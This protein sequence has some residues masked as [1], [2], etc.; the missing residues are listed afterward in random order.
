MWRRLPPAGHTLFSR[1]LSSGQRNE[2]FAVK[3][4]ISIWCIST[5]EFT[6]RARFI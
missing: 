1:R 6:P 5:F 4:L 2:T 3:R